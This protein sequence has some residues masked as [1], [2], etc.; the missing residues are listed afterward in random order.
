MKYVHFGE[1]GVIQLFAGFL[2]NRN[3]LL[4]KFVFPFQ[5]HVPLYLKSVM[6]IPRALLGVLIQ[7]FPIAL[8]NSSFIL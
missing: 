2:Q 1:G 5:S 8:Y 6:S 4:R 7:L 3:V